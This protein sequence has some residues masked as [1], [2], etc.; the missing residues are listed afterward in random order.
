MAI[1]GDKMGELHFKPS[2]EDCENEK[3]GYSE[4]GETVSRGEENET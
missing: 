2:L 1:M 3:F 4:L